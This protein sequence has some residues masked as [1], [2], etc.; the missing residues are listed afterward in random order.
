MARNLIQSDNFDRASLGADWQNL[1]AGI[2]GNVVTLTSTVITGEY[3]GLGVDHP[4][5][6][7]VGAG[8][9]TNDQY[10]SLEIRGTLPP[11]GSTYRIGAIVRASADVNAA[12]DYYEVYFN[13]NGSVTTYLVKCVNGTVTTLM[14][15]TSVAW[16]IGDLIELEVEG[17]QLRP[18]RN[19]TVIASLV[20]TDT[21]IT[22]GQPG[23]SV[24]QGMTGDNWTAGSI[25]VVAPTVSA[26]P[27]NS[28]VTEGA[29]ATFSATF[30]NS[31]TSYVWEQA[32]SPYSSWTTVTDGTGGATASYTTAVTTIGMTGRRYRCTATNTGGSATTDGT[33]QLTVNVATSAPNITV[34]PTP[35]TV[36]VGDTATFSLTATG[37]GTLTYQW[38]RSA[39]GGGGF[40]PIS[41]AVSSSYTTPV[42]TVTGGAANNGDTYRC[43]VHGDVAPDA[44]SN[45]VTLTVNVSSVPQFPGA[46]ALS[47]LTTSS[48]T[49]GWTAATDDVAVTGYERSL[50]GGTDWVDIGLVLSTAVSGRTPGTTDSC[51]IRAYDAAGNRSAALARSV[52]LALT[53]V[54]TEPLENDA[55]SL[56]LNAAVK[57]SWFPGG[58]IGAME[59]ITPLDGTGTTHATVGNLVIDGLPLG[60]GV[61]MTCKW[62]ATP[63]QDS[64]HYQHL[65]VV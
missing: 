25:S 22:T 47:L 24:T 4:A 17:S 65:T 2:R 27:G 12:R 15:T 1:S 40:A 33:A 3:A 57:W 51:R 53:Q 41:G 62:G 46:L 8:T 55:G 54:V 36:I 32:D 50:N 61:L 21:D 38:Q 26:Q 6:R 37:T 29:T 11:P 45:V 20:T 64:V 5:A 52:T 39:S 7:W 30:A 60:P 63:E 43:I 14:S 42:T 23:V 18:C 10:S 16:S 48:Y 9:F 49:L 13:W 59:G 44:T 28:S 19:G 31:P 34:Q 56:H 35:Q 58:R